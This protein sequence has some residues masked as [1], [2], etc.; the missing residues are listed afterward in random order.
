VRLL[1]V[2]CAA[3]ATV[4]AAAAPGAWAASP[5]QLYWSNAG[6][7][8]IGE[9]NLDGGASKPS[10]ITGLGDPFGLALDGQ[11]IYWASSGGAIG[12]ANLDGTN[13]NPAFI[14]G[15]SVPD[16]VAVD[17][18]HI[19]WANRS[20]GTIGEANLDGTDVNQNFITG[21]SLPFGLAVDGQHIYWANYGGAIGE[22]NLDGTNVNQTFIAGA[23]AAGVAVDGQHI[24]W[25]NVG[26]NTIGEANLD[27][28]QIN[29][30]FITGASLPVGITVDDQ[31]IYWANN[32][33]GTIGAANLDGTQINQSFITDAPGPFGVAAAVPV[34]TVTPAI[35]PSFPATPQGSLSGQPLT[36]TN[37]GQR[38]L[39]ITRLSITGPD[40]SDFFLAN[41]TC[42]GNIQPADSCQLEVYF[43]PQALGQRTA[44]LL[45][46]TNDYANSPLQLAL[47]GTG[48][49]PSA[50]PAGPQGLP[51]P[52]GPQGA[53][54]PAGP[55]GKVICRDTL[56]AKLVCTVLFAPGS[57]ST[58]GAGVASY[59]L[60][61]R[62]RVYA[63]GAF[64]IRSGRFTL[65]ASR[66][67]QPGS[68]R[69]TVALGRGR[70]RQIVIERMIRVP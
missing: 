42:W 39:T 67:L 59:T 17:R 6:T 10:L 56:A 40:A 49:S 38:P 62:H 27:G 22:A 20:S 24:Y 31:R 16:A 5:P 58:N 61:R 52:T 1:A 65:R 8:A 54:G 29:E 63:H 18:Q 12:E 13:V 70:D 66:R 33:G 15:G 32:V 30:S 57:W 7:G 35:P 46:A 36:V 44:T 45:L 64:T 50:G 41:Q 43:A 47:S 60:V 48:T 34:A 25:A 55:A 2:A 51:G 3:V 26:R 14:T 28:T 37:T 19:Y 9:A 69:L 68:Y 23:G 53:V 11:H 21:A 4:S